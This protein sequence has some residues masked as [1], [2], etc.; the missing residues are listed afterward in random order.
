MLAGTEHLAAR[1]LREFAAA[2]GWRYD[3]EAASPA[4]GA[5]LWEQVSSGVV[6]DRISGSGWEAGRITGGNRSASTVERRGRITV[7][8]TVI[9]N[10]PQQSLDVG[11]LAVRLPRRLSH[12]VLDA[13]SNDRGP[14]FSLIRRPQ[15]DQHLSLEGDFD[16]HFRLY[17]PTGYEPDALY[18][19]TPDLMAL[20]VDETGDLDVEIRENKLIV[21]KPAGF[22]LTDAAT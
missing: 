5:S 1:D 19:F 16:T 12:F 6:R 7:T 2:N 9:V 18:V 14:F 4:L 8:N 21:Y 3:A 13:V 22:D 20:L 10:T 17:A 11:Y 15:P